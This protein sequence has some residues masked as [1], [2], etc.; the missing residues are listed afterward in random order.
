MRAICGSRAVCLRP[1]L[2]NIIMLHCNCIAILP[3]ML[4]YLIVQKAQLVHFIINKY[5]EVDIEIK[6]GKG[7]TKNECTLVL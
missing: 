3:S 1:L 5:I 7:Q 6:K 4:F 2:Y